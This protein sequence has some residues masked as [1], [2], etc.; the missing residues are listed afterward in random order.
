MSRPFDDLHALLAALPEADRSAQAGAAA[1]LAVQGGLGRLGEAVQW[2][3]AWQGRSA[4][5]VRRP[6]V[7]LYAA[8]HEGSGEAEGAA[9]TRVDAMAAGEGAIGLAARELG[10]GVEVFDLAADRPCP[11]AAERAAM[12]ER[13][14]AATLA[15]GMEA[16]AKGPDLLIVGEITQGSD[17]A[18]GA[19][20]HALFGGAAADWSALPDWTAQAL[21]RAQRDGAEGPLD[22][23]RHLGGRETAAL[24]GAILAARVQKV[25]VLL[26]GYAAAAAGAV[27]QQL[28]SDAL[29]HCLAAEATT[30][31]GHEALLARIGKPPLLDLGI[32]RGA[33]LAG[34]A[35]LGLLRVGCAVQA[36]G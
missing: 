21:A 34:V 4:P 2:L 5:R 19:L 1:A 11:D 15:F 26:D 20:A 17:R 28:R 12:G 35:A 27:L 32:G 36:G 23:L 8:A 16:L 30:A 7:A 31:P 6:I 3:A 29:D 33:G 24:A 18:A 14:C 13:E 22:W 25:P 9:R 10:A